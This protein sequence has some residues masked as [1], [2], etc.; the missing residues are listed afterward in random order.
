MAKDI[1]E[2]SVAIEANTQKVWNTLINT[3]LWWDGVAFDATLG[4]I[5][6]EVWQE[7]GEKKTAE[8]RVVSFVPG[9]ELAVRWSEPQ[10]PKPM[11]FTFTLRVKDAKH[12]DV[13]LTEQ[14]WL[15]FPDDIR[16]DLKSEHSQGWQYHLQALKDV[17]ET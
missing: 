2:F 5:F 10:W 15:V 14:D 1:L 9:K 16:Q 13:T 11:T 3:G 7:D 17:T 4:G 6:R 12:T 8:G